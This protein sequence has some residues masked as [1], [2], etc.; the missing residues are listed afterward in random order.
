MKILLSR[1]LHTSVLIILLCSLS[2]FANAKA[3]PDRTIH[4]LG[5]PMQAIGPHLCQVINVKDQPV[6][7]NLELRA[8]DS[9]QRYGPVLFSF[10]RNPIVL[11]PGDV[12]RIQYENEM[13]AYCVVEYV[14]QPGD[15]RG[16]Y[17]AYDKFGDGTNGCT[18]LDPLPALL[19][20]ATWPVRN[21]DTNP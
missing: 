8:N 19:P 15:V 11:N 7:V 3:K 21:L 16:T 13:T 2:A 14:G 5:G 6:T 1:K 18:P 17:C 4:L 12:A 20:A 10:I 9:G